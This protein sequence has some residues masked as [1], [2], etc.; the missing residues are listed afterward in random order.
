MSSDEGS[1]VNLPLSGEGIGQACI[2]IALSYIA[3]AAILQP[4]YLPFFD[5]GILPVGRYPTPKA[6]RQYI[7]LSILVVMISGIIKYVQRDTE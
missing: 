3:V 4:Q 7:L 6:G 1:A 2:V 5:G